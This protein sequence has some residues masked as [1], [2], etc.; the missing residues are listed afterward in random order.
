[1]R[2]NGSI[3]RQMDMELI[4]IKKVLAIRDNGKMTF[5]QVKVLKCGLTG[6]NTLECT[7]MEINKAKVNI[8][9]M[10]DQY[11]MEIGTKMLSMEWVS[12]CGMMA[13]SIMEIGIRMTC[14]VSGYMFTQMV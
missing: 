10:M 3:T 2:A 5:N 11:M 14:M 13:E 8:F 6:A 1:M 12:I 7:K 9:G 4:T